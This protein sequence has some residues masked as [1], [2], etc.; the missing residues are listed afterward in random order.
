[1]D[2]GLPDRIPHLFRTLAARDG[3]DLSIFYDHYDA[4][5]FAHGLVTTVELA[6]LC[7]VLSVL[8]GA[9]V[10]GVRSRKHQS[11]NRR[12]VLVVLLDAYVQVFRNTPSVVQLYFF[13]FGLGPL[14]AHRNQYGQAVPL[15]GNFAWTVACLSIYGGALNAEALRG[16]IAAVQ[17][18]TFEAAEALGYSRWRAY[19]HV[20]LPLA[21]RFSFPVLRTNLV[22][23]IKTTSVAYTIAVP[24]TLYVSSEIWS[25]RMNVVE[26]MNVV[27]LSF[28]GLAGAFSLAAGWFERRLQIPGVGHERG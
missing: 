2:A 5:R 14:L 25:D 20:V 21:L 1:M 9:L 10:A 27:L 18:T 16:G 3:I 22:N 26:M 12:R 17:R 24:E 28:V 7:V 6:T 11:R 23:L 13:Y 4:T 15:I 8:I 19:V